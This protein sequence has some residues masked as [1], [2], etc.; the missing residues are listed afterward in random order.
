MSGTS[1]PVVE[2]IAVAASEVELYGCPYCGYRSF[3]SNVSG[4]GSACCRCGECEKQFVVLAEGVEQ[5]NI[6]IGG[7][8]SEAVYPK[9]QPHPRHGTP[10]HGAP[11]KKPDNGEFFN[12]RGIGLDTT[13]GCFVC[14]G[15]AGLHNNIAAFV[16]CKAAGE[17]VVVMF[18]TGARLDY[19]EH[20]PDRVQVKIGACKKHAKKLERLETLTAA[21]NGVITAEMV[22]QAK[23]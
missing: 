6:G 9:L 4:G 15:D 5:S 21:A 16:Q 13:P 3:F 10:S 11:D 19:R 20:S 1:T 22:T 14:G 7:G 17:R 2:I 23:G 8:D 12:S 18:K